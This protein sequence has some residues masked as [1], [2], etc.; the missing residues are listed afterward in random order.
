M[1]KFLAKDPEGLD[2]IRKAGDVGMSHG[3]E[4]GDVIELAGRDVAG[5][6]KTCE[7]RGPGHLEAG[8]SALGASQG[9]IHDGPALGRMDGAGRLGGDEGL[10]AHGINDE[11]FHKLRLDNRRGDLQEGFVFEENAAFE[12]GID[13]AGEPEPLEIIQK[14]VRKEAGG[15]QISQIFITEP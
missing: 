7:I 9:K 13:F 6:D 11:R 4:D 8:V 3:A 5:A 15:F 14:A 1:G 2:F 10:E 12:Q